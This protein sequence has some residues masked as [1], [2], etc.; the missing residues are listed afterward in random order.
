[1]I[2]NRMMMGAAGNNL[3][4]N[5]EYTVFLAHM[6]GVDNAQVFTDSGAGANCPHTITASGNVKTE[7]T[8]KRFG[9]TSGYFDG[10]G[11]HLTVVDSTDFDWGTGNFT[12]DWWMYTTNK[13]TTAAILGQYSAGSVA[14]GMFELYACNA[15]GVAKVQMNLFYNSWSDG[16]L[17]DPDEHALNTWIHWAIVRDSAT[18]L[19]LYKD[20]VEKHDLTINSGQTINNLAAI[21]LYIGTQSDGSSL[22]FTGYIDELRISKG[23]ARWTANFTPPTAAYG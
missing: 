17:V 10:T 14:R 21:P 13:D 19:K 15:N 22:P 11:D 16:S 3:Y 7:N 12:L 5:D 23:I 20:G 4:G 9:V 18:S 6:E 8:Q 2:V 1:M